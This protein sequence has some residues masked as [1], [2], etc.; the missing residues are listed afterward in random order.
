MISTTPIGSRFT[1]ACVPAIIS[2]GDAELGFM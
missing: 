1:Q 2:D